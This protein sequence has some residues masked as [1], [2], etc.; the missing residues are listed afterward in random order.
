MVLSCGDNS[1]GCLGHSAVSSL[2]HPKPIGIWFFFQ[3]WNTFRNLSRKFAEVLDGTRIISVSCGPQHVV[4]LDSENFVYS[5]G[6]CKGGGL[7][8]G[9]KTVLRFDRRGLQHQWSMFNLVLPYSSSPRRINSSFFNQ[10][11]LKVVCG[12]ECSLLLLD[13][14]DILATGRN[15]FNRLGFGKGTAKSMIFVSRIE[16]YSWSMNCLT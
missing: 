6:Y 16:T 1:K 2:Q 4:A 10:P 11:I 13:S 3:Y 9:V 8:L 14:G 7:G 5:W 12:V 15:T